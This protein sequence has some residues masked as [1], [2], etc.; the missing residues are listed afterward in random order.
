MSIAEAYYRQRG[1]CL[2]Y[3]FKKTA[4]LHEDAGEAIEAYNEV[5]ISAVEFFTQERDALIDLPPESGQRMFVEGMLGI[6][7][8]HEMD[9]GNASLT[10]DDVRAEAQR[11]AAELGDIREGASDDLRSYVDKLISGMRDLHNRIDPEGIGA[12]TSEEPIADEEPSLPDEEGSEEAPPSPEDSKEEEEAA[13]PEPESP[14]D[15][16]TALGL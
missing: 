1:Y 3:R 8:Q 2:G 6:L 15:I 9:K 13:P 16:A 5:W 4:L 11:V 10:N 14:D 7:R 12:D